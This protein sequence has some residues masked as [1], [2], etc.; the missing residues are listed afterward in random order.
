MWSA[1][2]FLVPQVSLINAQNFNKMLVGLR[3]TLVG[4]NSIVVGLEPYR[5][6]RKRRPWME[7]YIRVEVARATPTS[8]TAAPA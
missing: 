4:L 5:A 7:I 2:F 3:K 8:E 6:Y 1:Y